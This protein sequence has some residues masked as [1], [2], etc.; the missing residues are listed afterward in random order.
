M[1]WAKLI[2][3]GIGRRS[4]EAI[5]AGVVLAIAI[6]VVVDSLMVVEGARAALS[7]AERDDRPDIVRV[8]SR[9]N[10]ALF[11]TPRSGT[12][13][14]MTLPVYEPLIDPAQLAPM[15]NRATVVARQ[16]FLRNVVFDE[17]F[18]NIYVFGIEPDLERRISKFSLSRGRFL[19]NDDHDAAVLDQ[20]SARALGVDI[21]G[22]FP[23]RKADGQDLG[24]TVV[25]ILETATLRDPPPRTVEAPSP[26]ADSSFVFGGVFVS[27]RTSEAI[28]GR[29]T[30]TN[31]LIVAPSLGDVPSVVDQLQEIFRL[32]PGVFIAERYNQF[33]RK[34]H[35]FTLTLGLFAG[36]SA[37]TT[38]LAVAFASNLLH[39]VYADRRRQFGVLTALGFSA[40]WSLAPD[41]GLG[42]ATASLGAIV[43]YLMAAM[44]GPKQ[45]A[46]PSLMA[47]L[48]VVEPRFDGL[49]FAAMV[50]ITA[51]AIV[52]GIV[53]TALQLR[54]T[55]IART[56]SD[57]GR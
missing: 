47:D 31:A 45:F 7:Q 37:A 50:I 22:S 14:P 28:F 19:R 4:F 56:L 41:V 40:T 44:L 26:T 1:I 30:L 53:P 39:D 8:T 24:L 20:L 42:L 46:M 2:F 10:R 12:L 38:L 55:S 54:R 32:E 21:G 9:F 18:L 13:P 6:A 3:G 33:F 15:A 27:L 36:I 49:V 17:G 29:P 25:G 57:D 43:A 16:S 5:A 11:E 23:I 48:G 51:T 34:V 35:D 52:L